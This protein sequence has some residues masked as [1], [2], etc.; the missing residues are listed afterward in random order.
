MCDEFA[1]VTST[2]CFTYRPVYRSAVFVSSSFPITD[3]SDV[4]TVVNTRAFV[5]ALVCYKTHEAQR[6]TSSSPNKSLPPPLP[7]PRP[8]PPAPFAVPPSR[9][10]RA[11]ASFCPA[12]PATCGPFTSGAAATMRLTPPA[13]PITAPPTPS[14]LPPLHHPFLYP[15]TASPT[16]SSPPPRRRQRPRVVV[17]APALSLSP[18]R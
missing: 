17:V 18:A 10:K 1:A 13:D 7:I 2:A 14:R 15:V 12:Y 9:N 5:C 8:A 6:R 4:A 3:F 16:S 11:G